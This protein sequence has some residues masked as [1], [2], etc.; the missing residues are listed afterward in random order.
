M[1]YFKINHGLHEYASYYP[2]DRFEIIE[3][4]RED[5]HSGLTGGVEQR[6]RNGG[7]RKR[8]LQC[9]VSSKSERHCK[10]LL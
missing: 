9:P 3:G 4:L 7:F 1:Y 2:S 8:Y 10:V 6:F 5:K